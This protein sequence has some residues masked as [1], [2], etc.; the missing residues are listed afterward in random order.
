[1][2]YLFFFMAGLKYKSD[3]DYHCLLMLY[4]VLGI[5]APC[6][7]IA[8]RCRIQTRNEQAK[9]SKHATKT[10]CPL[11]LCN[12]NNGGI[13]NW[14]ATVK[15]KRRKKMPS[16][17]SKELLSE[18]HIEVP[19]WTFWSC[20]EIS[21]RYWWFGC[22]HNVQSSER[23]V[24]MLLAWLWMES[25]VWVLSRRHCPLRKTPLTPSPVFSLPLCYGNVCCAS[26]CHTFMLLE[27][28]IIHYMCITRNTNAKP[29]RKQTH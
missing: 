14:C 21:L 4:I 28:C 20:L 15:R 2:L 6:S 25:I 29:P 24:I 27:T 22:T 10:K 9:M 1:M 5:Y 8:Q 11:W 19:V 26:S 3:C 7:V 17:D 18:A 12:I 13:N 23:N 16:W